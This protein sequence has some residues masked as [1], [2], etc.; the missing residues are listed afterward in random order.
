MKRSLQEHEVI[1][2]NEDASLMKSALRHILER[3]TS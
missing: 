3:F 1:C 2:D